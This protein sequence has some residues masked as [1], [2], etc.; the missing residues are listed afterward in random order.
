MNEWK[1][2][3]WMGIYNRKKRLDEMV[4]VY[5]CT[6]LYAAVYWFVSRLI[7]LGRDSVPIDLISFN[8]NT[9]GAAD[10]RSQ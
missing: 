2:I 4:V 3:Q 6:V 10:R 5:A 8:L 7:A 1:A 9:N